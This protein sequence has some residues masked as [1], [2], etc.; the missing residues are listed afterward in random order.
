M[1]TTQLDV[2]ISSLATP[3][4]A[5][6]FRTIN[7]E[8]I[9]RLFTLTDEDRKVLGDPLGQI[10]NPGGDVLFAHTGD[11]EV[12]GCVA[13]LPYGDGIF[14][15][16]KMGVTPRAQG[17]G[18]GRRLVGAALARAAKL[19]GRRV[20][21][22]TNSLLAPAIHLYEAAG[23]HRITRDQLPVADYYA[24]ADILMEKSLAR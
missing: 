24:R 16:S 15:L 13:L 12:V 18:I 4:E 22:G 21:L 6:A 20:F 3:S 7:E 14:E 17:A 2:S 1:S 19:G 11:G 9:A 23:F 10:V 8:W 5:T